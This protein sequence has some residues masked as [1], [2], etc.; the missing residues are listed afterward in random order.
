M[1][2]LT[3][4]QSNIMAYCLRKAKYRWVHDLLSTDFAIIISISNMR[5]FAAFLTKYTY[6]NYI[7][8]RLHILYITFIR[9]F[10]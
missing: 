6:N 7:L 2:N 1:G 4:Y 9:I 5:G 3:K 10:A 8:H